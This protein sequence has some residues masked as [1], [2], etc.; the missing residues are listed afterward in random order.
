MYVKGNKTVVQ[1]MIDQYSKHYD[2]W[3]NLYQHKD[4][5]NVVKEA[6]AKM[7]SINIEKKFPS[8]SGKITLLDVATPVTFNRYVNASRGTYMGFLYTSKSSALMFSGKVPF[9]RKIY[10]SGQYVQCPGGLPLAMVAGN[11]SIQRIRYKENT[12]FKRYFIRNRMK[13]KDN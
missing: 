8:L 2:Y 6:V 4:F 10:L 11:H 1:V 12:L 5:Y 9:L 7:V 13:A 3:A